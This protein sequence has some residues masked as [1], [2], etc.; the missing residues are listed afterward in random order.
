METLRVF[1]PL[2]EWGQNMPI[3]PTPLPIYRLSV[4]LWLGFTTVATSGYALSTY[5]NAAA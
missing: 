3:P 4:C 5:R 1:K 2:T